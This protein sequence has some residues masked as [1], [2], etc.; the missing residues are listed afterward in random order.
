[1]A[2]ARQ[3]MLTGG[4]GPPSGYG[5]TPIPDPTVLTSTLVEK[6]REDIRREI[7]FVRQILTQRLDKMDEANA[8]V[9]EDRTTLPHKLEMALNGYRYVVDQQLQ[10][11]A[12][13]FA[14]I[15]IQFHE[16]DGRVAAAFQGQRD[17]TAA[18]NANIAQSL[19]RIESQAQR[20]IEQLVV[21]LQTTTA[22]ISD[23]VDDLKQRLTLIEG[24]TAGITA[25]GTNQLATQQVAQGASGNILAL[26]AV[27][28]AVLAIIASVTVA[29]L[30][31]GG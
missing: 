7:D 26:I 3:E 27:V 15:N 12:E 31:R 4:H 28:V 20:Q 6:A 24:R 13:K 29:L 10:V 5:W 16:R 30:P 18:Q 21:L 11:M 19:A 23:K 17:M 1:M 9:Q 22:G 25:A 14:A 2:D 8:L